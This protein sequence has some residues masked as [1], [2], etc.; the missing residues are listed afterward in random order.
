MSY[1]SALSSYYEGLSIN[2]IRRNLDQQY[3]VNPSSETVFSW[4]NKYTN[5]A[6]GK[7]KDLH[8]EVGD[9]WIADETYVRVD[10]RKRNEAEVINPYEA[11]KKDRWVIFWDIIDSDTRYLLASLVTTTRGTADAKK[12]MEL[13]EKRAGK[14][15]KV[16]VTDSLKVYLDGIEQAYGSETTHKQG[17]PFDIQNNTNL[18]ERFHSTL[19]ERTKVMR[20]LRNK[21]TT[22]TFTDG[23]L[24]YYNY[25]KPH[26]SLDNKTPAETAKLEYPFKNWSD[27]TNQHTKPKVTLSVET[28][29]EPILTRDTMR[30]TPS[31]RARITPHRP[32]ITN[33]AIDLGAGVV[34]SKRRRHIK[35]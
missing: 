13:A 18:I 8:P 34:Q 19:K 21:E 9:T 20:A 15:P 6:I 24:L 22:Q 5:E 1:S 12:L 27:I 26:M 10:R 33:R 35:L 17:S 32:R 25:L 28:I 11:T 2:A 4:V 14:T 16:V 30:I 3:H 31:R 23:W 7:T 29:K